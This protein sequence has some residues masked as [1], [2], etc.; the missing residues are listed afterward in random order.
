MVSV[1]QLRT[2]GKNCK[3]FELDQS[4]YANNFSM[5]IANGD[6]SCEICRH[7]DVNRKICRIG[8]FDDVLSSLDQS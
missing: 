8:V 4:L 1:E 3:D 2:V 6:R 5:S 7:W